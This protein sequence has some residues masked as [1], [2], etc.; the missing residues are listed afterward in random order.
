MS[1]DQQKD[2]LLLAIAAA[3]TATGV[4]AGT[5]WYP[6]FHPVTVQEFSA[7]ITTS[8]TVTAT[9]LALKR[10]PTPGSATGEVIILTLTLPVAAVIGNVYYKRGGD[11]K[12]SPGDELVVDVTQA[13]TAGAATM[14]CA[15]SPSWEAPANNAKMIAS[16]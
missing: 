14:G 6:P 13:S 2:Q 15:W 11:T 3:T 9:I 16:A 5:R 8:P 4:I 1:Y 12:I 10:R 7:Q